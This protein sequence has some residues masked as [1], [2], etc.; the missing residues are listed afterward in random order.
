MHVAKNNCLNLLHLGTYS[1]VT[2]LK[3]SSECTICPGGY[4]CE[5][6]GL[7]APTGLCGEGIY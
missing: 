1:N 3:M 6:E 4:Y 7:T 5:T 2:N